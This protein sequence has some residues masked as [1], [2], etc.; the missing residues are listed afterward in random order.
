M[1]FTTVGVHCGNAGEFSL[2]V[3]DS[4]ASSEELS[5]GVN[6]TVVQALHFCLWIAAQLHAM[7][8]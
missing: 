8:S 3:L 4:V 2:P 6:L 7:R 1:Y 5:G